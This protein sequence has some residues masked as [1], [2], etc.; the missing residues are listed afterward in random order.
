MAFKPYKG[1]GGKYRMRFRYKGKEY[2]QVVKTKAD[3]E[4]WKQEKL[5]EL[6][7]AD[8][9]APAGLTLS[10]MFETYMDDCRARMR[11]QTVDEKLRHLTKFA[12][13]LGQDVYPEQISIKLAQSF[14][15]SVQRDKTN[16]T[17]NR[18]LRTVKAC[19]NWH[20][21]KGERID[22]PWNNVEK[23]PE[24]AHLKNV[25]SAEQVAAV[26]MAANPF[27]SD[28]LQL[29]LQT[30]ARPGEIRLLKWDDVI[31]DRKVLI[32]WTRKRRGGGK[33][34]RPAHMT[35]TMETILRRRWANHPGGPWV[36]THPDTGKN[37]ERHSN[38]IQYMMTRLCKKADVSF[39]DLYSL[40]HYVSQRVID[41]GKAKPVDVQR[42]LGHQR[43]TTTDNYIKSLVP[44]M[45]NLDDVLESILGQNEEENAQ[46]GAQQ[47]GTK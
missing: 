9:E 12:D 19:W 29:I 23:Y 5:A 28:Y 46:K 8:K 38:A 41:S 18:Y 31:F 17:A 43:L 16:K 27:Q 21:K 13:S 39:F 40:R 25:P 15:S 34:P 4:T 36:F 47:G 11:P 42:L 2:S 1:P 32:L 37:Y 30:A 22:N 20:I 6:K 44:D 14:I 26:L 3:G 24:E 7:K 45:H 35:K 10:V 33:T